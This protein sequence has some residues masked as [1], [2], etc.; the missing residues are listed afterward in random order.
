MRELWEP[1]GLPQPLQRGRVIT[2]DQVY[3]DYARVGSMQI[4]GPYQK[5][6]SGLAANADVTRHAVAPRHLRLS[7]HRAAERGGGAPR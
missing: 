4:G 6:A 5:A 3:M 2:D 1:E 7:S